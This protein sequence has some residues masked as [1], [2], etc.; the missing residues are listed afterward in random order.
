MC[1]YI[2]MFLVLLVLHKLLL[3]MLCILIFSS[4]SESFRYLVYHKKYVMGYVV[5]LYPSIPH[6]MRLKA[7]R[8]I[9]DK[10]EQNTIPTSDKDCRFCSEE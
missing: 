6:E 9:L 7:L 1:V 8:E 3:H 2:L 4:C 10:R 5:G